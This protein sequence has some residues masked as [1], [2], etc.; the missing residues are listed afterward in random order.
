MIYGY[1][2]VSTVGQSI[3]GS[4][5]EEQVAALTEY[6]CN[7]IITEA[8]T[9]KTVDRP[10]FTAL[11]S[12]LQS[13]DTLVV[14]KLDRFARSTVEG[15]Q[16]VRDL[17]AR[18]VKVHILNIGLIENTLSGNLIL[19]VFLAFAEFERGMILERTQN[20]KALAKM[21]PGFREGRPPKYKPAQ[22]NHA[23]ELLGSGLS[24]RQV[25]NVTGISKSTL[26]RAKRTKYHCEHCLRRAGFSKFSGILPKRW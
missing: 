5:L 2:R 20:G 23:L 8:Y 22:I 12:K 9:G 14:T 1:A 16:T 25:E 24:Y 4:S 6:G 10:Q 15:V 7:Q 11:L 26:V 21:Q 3:N 17:F 19:T 13:G 18:D